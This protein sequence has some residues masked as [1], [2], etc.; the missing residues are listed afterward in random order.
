MSQSSLPVGP[1]ADELA[2]ILDEIVRTPLLD[3]RA[4][5]RIL[6][7]H[8]KDGR[9]FYRKREILAAFRA[10][11]GRWPLDEPA[12]AERLR[13]C[14]TRTLSGVTP[15]TVL[16]KPFPCPGRCVFCPSD[17][18]M[19]KSYL[20]AEPGCQRAAANRFDPYLQTWNRLRAYRE[21]GHATDKAELIV[22]GGTWSFYPEAYQLWFLTRCLEALNDFGA[23]RDHRAAVGSAGGHLTQIEAGAAGR[24][25]N[26][27]V[28]AHLRRNQAGALL[29]DAERGSWEALFRAQRDNEAA[30]ARQVGL[31]LETRP[32]C[33]TREEVLRLRRL[34]A[35]KVQLGI[36]SLDDQVLAASRRGHD[37]AASRRAMGLLRAAGFKLQVHWMA[38][39]PGATPE[40]D[41]RD[42]GRLFSDPALCPDELKIYPCSLVETAELVEHYE[43]GDWRPYSQSELVELL[44][45]C[46]ESVPPWCRVSRVIRDIPS[47]DILV[48]NQRTNLREAVEERVGRRGGQ[49]REI[50]SREVRGRPVCAESLVLREQRYQ[51]GGG[52]ECFLGLETG[53]GSLAGFLRLALPERYDEPPR[54]L[55]GCAVIRELHVYGGSLSLGSRRQGAAQHQGAGGRLVLRAAQLAGEAGYRRLAVISAVG[56]RAYYRGQGFRLPEGALYPMRELSP[57]GP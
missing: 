45:D 55:A 4:L 49:L 7:R 29:A 53:D 19:P 23:G 47:P 36:Q 18:R 43:R 51:G 38:N 48:G 52:Q 35:T 54:A 5:D 8:P 26:G 10:Q 50:R 15:V 57:K 25:Y 21:M 31:S 32:D 28:A 17:V 20:S 9:G 42:F 1:R 41:R 44:A 12:L 11:P 46:L 3:A 24:S 27:S 13:T 14:P 6:R 22:L 39:L 33:V 37:V 16:T 40:G 56:T 2:A 30:G 34:G